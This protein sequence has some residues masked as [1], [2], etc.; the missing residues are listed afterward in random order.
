MDYYNNHLK[1]KKHIR[2]VEKYNKAKVFGYYV[3]N[4]SR[5]GVV[6]I[7]EEGLPIS[8]QEKPSNPK[9]RYAITGIYFYDN[10]AIKKAVF[11]TK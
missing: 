10:S 5:Y 4:P 3:N 1:T 7:S 6:E 11:S 9:S 8:I 2:N